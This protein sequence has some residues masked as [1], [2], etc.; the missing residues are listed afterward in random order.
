VNNPILHIGF[1]KTGTTW[2]FESYYKYVSGIYL[3]HPDTYLSDISKPSFVFPNYDKTK[4]LVLHHPDLTGVKRFIW[5]EGIQREKIA[6]NL[7][8]NFP[9]A[10]II[11]FLR[12]QIDFLTSVYLYYVRKGGTYSAKKIIQLMIN[13]ELAFTLD[14]L[15]YDETLEVYMKLFGKENV[16][17]YLYEEFCKQPKSFINDFTEKYKF[18]I[19]QN[20]IDYTPV[21]EK[22]RL[23]LMKLLLKTNRFTK[24]DNPFKKHIIH[25][26]GLYQL[27]NDNFH[28]WNKLK[29]FGKKTKTNDLFSEEQILYLKEYYKSSNN[30]LCS[31][32]SIQKIKEYYPI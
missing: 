24:F 20:K 23:Q 9:D 22:L 4:Q 1:P 10:T 28:Q 7:K 12:N 11:I 26:P 21:N 29:I 27:I 8:N 15:K 6:T 17:V 30:L 3:P 25:I 2:F 31:N 32:Y 5:D 16:H 14:Y 18:T 19:A 13:K